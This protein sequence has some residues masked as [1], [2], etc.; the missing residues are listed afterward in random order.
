VLPASRLQCA[1]CSIIKTCMCG[2]VYLAHGALCLMH[3]LLLSF[4]QRYQ[5]ISNLV[6]HQCTRHASQSLRFLW[7]P[8]KW[9]CCPPS[10]IRHSVTT[11]DGEC[12]LARAH[13][14]IIL[15]HSAA[16]EH[17]VRALFPPPG[18]FDD[19]QNETARKARSR[20]RAL[21]DPFTIFFFQERTNTAYITHTKSTTE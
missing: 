18:L 19:Q 1:I 11:S 12:R 2:L 20:W 3:P 15:I 7:L 9:G 21:A 16:P 6:H 8:H 4:V 14:S 17:Q 5:G 13:T 10:Y